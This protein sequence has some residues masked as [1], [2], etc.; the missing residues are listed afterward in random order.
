MKSIKKNILT[1]DKITIKKALSIIAKTG[2]KCLVIVDNNL[3][4]LGTLSDGDLRRA[5]LK[6]YDINKNIKKI[7]NK[8]PFYIFNKDLKEN[9]LKKIFLEKNFVLIPVLNK[10]NK[11][12]DIIYWEE[13]FSNKKILK[14]NFKTII[15]A[16][17]KGTRL[18]PFTSVL[19]KPLIP[20]NGKPAIQLIIEKLNNFGIKHFYISLNYKANVLKAFFSEIKSNY[21]FNFIE[22]K[23]PLG[24]IGCLKLIKYKKNT[25]VLLTNCDI[26][27]DFNINDFYEYHKKSKNDL[28]IATSAKDFVIPYGTC[29]VSSE[30]KLLNL[31]EKPSYSK[32]INIGL[33][34][35]KSST[36]NYIPHNKK[37][38]VTDFIKILKN[39]NKNIGLYP[40]DL[41]S[42]SDVGQWSEYNE[43]LNKFIN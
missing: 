10:Q 33:Y 7:Y 29:E 5:I 36:L 17:G 11:I 28:T 8:K 35:I 43:T 15:M 12:I 40:V 6:N 39:K 32:L 38:D 18:H 31:H 22:E 19:P 37:F 25:D 4:L 21:K 41:E 26:L 14:S 9:I 30:G 16:G 34:F 13:I 2:K 27:F 20:V 24:T 1:Q 23:K 42:W 3:K